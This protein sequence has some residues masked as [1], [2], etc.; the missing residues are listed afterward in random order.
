MQLIEAQS[1]HQ[2]ENDINASAASPPAKRTRRSTNAVNNVK[3]NSKS[4][5]VCDILTAYS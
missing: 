1:D 5:Q 2:K 4:N 3:A